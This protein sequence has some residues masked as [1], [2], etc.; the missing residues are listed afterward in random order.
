MTKR[1]LK[2]SEN[3]HEELITSNTEEI[4]R[5]VISVAS[6]RQ[7]GET[8]WNFISRC[9]PRAKKEYERR[10]DHITRVVLWTLYNKNELDWENKNSTKIIKLKVSKIIMQIFYG[11]LSFSVTMR[12]RTGNQTVLIVKESNWCWIMDVTYPTDNNV[13]HKEERKVDRY[14]RLSGCLRWK[15]W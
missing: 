4:D 15:R 8:V 9:T 13:R 14:Y 5:I 3:E 1:Y 10:P 11:I 6:G 2:L 12:C 7:N